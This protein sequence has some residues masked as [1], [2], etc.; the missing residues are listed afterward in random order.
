MRLR[1]MLTGLLIAF[2]FVALAAIGQQERAPQ[3]ES[4][5]E[6]CRAAMPGIMKQYNNAKYAVQTA[7]SG[8]DTGHILTAV[9]QAKAALNA[10]NQPLQLCS[11]ALQNVKAG[12]S[13]KN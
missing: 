1:R 7:Q 5:L 11:D 3:S 12:Q 13:G 4:T 2:C 9:N 10:M 8:G 6:N